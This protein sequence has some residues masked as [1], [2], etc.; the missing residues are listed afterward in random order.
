MRILCD[1][2]IVIPRKKG[3]WTHYRIDTDGSKIAIRQLQ[4]LTSEEALAT[5][6]E[7]CK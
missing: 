6:N 5:C 3:K 4:K 2:G 7:K 1:A